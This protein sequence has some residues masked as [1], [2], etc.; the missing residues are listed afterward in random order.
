MSEN[1]H[2]SESLEEMKVV[3]VAL[4]EDPIWKSLPKEVRPKVLT[5]VGQYALK[6]TVVSGPLPASE[7]LAKYEQIAPR[8]GK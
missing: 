2:E 6:K 3:S 1:A 7:E 8:S 5:L 4:K